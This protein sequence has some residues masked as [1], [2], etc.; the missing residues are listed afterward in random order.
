MQ[1]ATTMSRPPAMP[2]LILLLVALLGLGACAP[3]APR[4]ITPAP[5]PPGPALDAA[6]FAPELDTLLPVLW[7]Q[8]AT[9]YRGGALQAYAAAH[10]ALD[11][12]LADPG[13]TAAQEQGEE[14]AALPPAIILDV[15]ETVLDNTP[16]QAR[17]LHQ[18]RRYDLESWHAWCEERQAKPVPGAV[19]FTQYA[20]SR[21]VTV[22]YVTNRR[23]VVTAA[24]RDNLERQGFPLA[25][26]RDVVLTRGLRPE[27]DSADKG[28]R[29]AAVAREF[30]ILLLVGDDLGDFL[31][32]NRTSPAERARLVAPFDGWWG[33]R[34][35][36][37]PNPIYGSWA[38]AIL[39]FAPGLS[40]QE[41]LKRRREALGE[42]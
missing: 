14:A 16:Y 10:A 42:R 8:T 11:R 21:G 30:R 1:H 31:P 13:W 5:L 40:E 12:A 3:P 20:A 6:H 38:D 37:V 26:G 28:P 35:I 27:W 22:F 4:P 15:D 18:G 2:A 24:T 9:E 33:S 41:A 7:L 29:R 39:G 23:A 19:A 36:V 25:S 32:G 17:L 34:W